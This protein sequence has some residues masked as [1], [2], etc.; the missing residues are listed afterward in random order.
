MKFR[1]VQN[2]YCQHINRNVSISGP[3]AFYEQFINK[4]GVFYISLL[5]W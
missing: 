2:H 3:E 5:K 1:E 4:I